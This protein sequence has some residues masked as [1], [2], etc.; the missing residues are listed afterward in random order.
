[1]KFSR[2]NCSPVATGR[3]VRPGLCRASVFSGTDS[4]DALNSRWEPCEEERQ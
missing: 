1:M 3:T 2:V 4:L